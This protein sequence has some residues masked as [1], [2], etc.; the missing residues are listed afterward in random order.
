[1]V[2]LQIPRYSHCA[3]VQVLGALGTDGLLLLS[4]TP[5]FGALALDSSDAYE[6]LWR[7]MADP[8]TA[9]E[10]APASSTP[11]HPLPSDNPGAAW[12]PVSEQ[13]AGWDGVSGGAG[14]REAAGVRT[15]W[16]MASGGSG[17][18]GLGS[19][20]GQEAGWKQ[21]ALAAVMEDATM[22]FS[23][24]PPPPP[25]GTESVTGAASGAATEEEGRGTSREGGM[26][27]STSGAAEEVS[28]VRAV[29]LRCLGHALYRQ[30]R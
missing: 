9:P 30:R 3:V 21:P 25:L 20:L 5:L 17:G 27:Q 23:S 8:R 4:H 2:L 11:P 19:G 7:A 13:G 18:W 29:A 28:I 1:M 6:G 22:S 16:G 26:L 14:T 24:L 10:H 12:A 15:S